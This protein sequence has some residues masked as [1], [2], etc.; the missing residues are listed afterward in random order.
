MPRGLRSSIRNVLIIAVVAT[1]FAG[2]YITNSSPLARLGVSTQHTGL[3]LRPLE[4]IEPGAPPCRFLAG[5]EGV[6]V[7]MR[8][9]ATEIKDKLPVHF[10][11]T[12]RCYPDTLIFSDYAEVFQGH[13]VH[14]ALANVDAHLKET[15]ADFAHYLRLQVLGREGLGKDELH[16][17]TWESGPVGKNDN[18]GWRLDKWKFLPMIQDTLKLRP[19][20]QWYVF[21]E[22]DTYVVWSN[23]VQWL[24][25]LEPTEASY[26][27]SEV[28]IGNDVFAHG[29]SA[30]VLSNPAMRKGAEIYASHPEEWHTRTAQHWA[31][32]CILGTALVS[33][34]VPF[35]WAWPMFQGGNPVDMD[36]EDAK[37]KRRLWCAPA[38][39]YHHFETHEVETMWAFEQQHILDL[40]A[41]MEEKK[42][43]AASSFFG[44]TD[45][46]LRHSD[47][48]RRY[49]RPNLVHE[50]TDWTNMSPD[51]IE[52]S[53][54]IAKPI[55][56]RM[57]DC[58]AACIAKKTCLQYAVS[59]IG[60]STSDHFKTGR[61]FRGVRSGWILP[62]VEHWT[63]SMDTCRRR[64][65]WSVT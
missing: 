48:F 65:G 16:G 47:V 59:A 31:G 32:D 25:T 38:L 6:V 46:I 52:H 19:E 14:D 28:L 43:T 9:G 13:Q 39:S 26:Y 29:G 5:A 58:E 57:A 44:G 1:V 21:V 61:A 20:K 56:E 49:I 12:L 4:E 17:E 41:V 63:K 36:W 33:A 53:A 23:M 27:G 42:S 37:E 64:G 50:R 30:F 8:T 15:N 2:L 22:P 18:P 60:C 34:G 7:V 3:R 45:T 54:R 62:R 24:Q 11:T 55:E 10:N 35:T 51:L 40:M